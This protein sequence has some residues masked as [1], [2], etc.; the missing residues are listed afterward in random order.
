MAAAWI[1][2]D[3]DVLRRLAELVDDA[4]RG[5]KTAMLLGEIRALEREFGLTP[6]ARRRLEWEIEHGHDAELEAEAKKSEPAEDGRWLRA[7]K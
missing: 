6:L 1:E 2:S 5:P 3:V 7:V 4:K